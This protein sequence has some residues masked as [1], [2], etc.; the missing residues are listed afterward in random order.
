MSLILDA[1]F[2][3]VAFSHMIVDILNGT[4]AV[5]LTF[6]STPLGLSNAALGFISTL[7]II[8]A[9]LIQPFF[10]YL[11]DRVGA[12]W[13]VSGGVA[14]MGTFFALA[15]IIPGKTALVFLILA[16]LGSGAF[17]P[18][19]GMQ[20]SVLGRTL[21]AG[22]ETSAASFFFLFGQLGYFF[23]PL[24]AGPLL[25]AFG[26]P[27]LLALVFWTAPVA[28]NAMRKLGK[29]AVPEILKPVR[30]AQSRGIK[31]GAGLSIVIGFAGIA[32]CQSW[33]QQNIV[34]FVPKYLSDLGQSATSYGIV[35][36]VFMG[37]SALGNILGGQL[38]DRFGGRI[39]ASLSLLFAV[40]P[41]F[42]IP[43]VAPSWLYI[44]VPVAGFFTGATQSIIVVYGQH[45]VPGGMAL[46]TGLVLGFTFSSGAIGTFFS[47]MIADVSGF[48]PVFHLSAGLALLAALLSTRIFTS[49][50]ATGVEAPA[51]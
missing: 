50:P 5:L 32:A 17:H 41:L 39:V 30:Q 20:A 29:L 26:P 16:S 42:L 24:L 18:A 10:G 38:A 34:T 14:W 48:S 49:R 3:S 7:Y 36:A 23:G 37:G 1:I 33:A 22:R 15:L 43:E 11:A 27:G 51:T 35:S 12:R 4:R 25:Q 31:L 45:L 8:S 46:A 9:A 2:S 40:L 21:Y 44:L 28:W 47:G 13:V 6:L 19:G